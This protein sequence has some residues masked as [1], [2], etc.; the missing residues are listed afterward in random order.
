MG[1][2]TDDGKAVE[3]TCTD[4]YEV[5]ICQSSAVPFSYCLV[6]PDG[7]RDL[8]APST[9]HLDYVMQ[10]PYEVVFVLG[11]LVCSDQLLG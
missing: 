4:R 11:S 2:F 10:I 7:H 9:Y 8:R 6:H 5:V 1:G 3:S